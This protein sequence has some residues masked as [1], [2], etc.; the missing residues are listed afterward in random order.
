MRKLTTVW[1][2]AL[3]LVALAFIG[4][5]NA[6][7]NTEPPGVARLSFVRGGVSMQRGDSGD[8]SAADLNTPLV[9]G[10]KIFTGSGSRAEIQL[11]WADML[12][13]D[14]N[15]EAHIATLDNNNI[16]VQLAQG[17]AYFSILKGSQAS[18]EIDTPNVAINPRREG[19]FRI[20][21]TP[22]GE[23]LITARDGDAD[24]STPEGSTP[25]K[26]G[27][28][29]TV[30]GSGND[31][32]FQIAQAPGNDE[33]DRWNSDRD[34]I[35]A[36][37][38]SYRHTNPYYTGAADLDAYGSW[39]NVPDYGWVWVPRVAL[40]WAPYRHGRWVWEPYWGWTWSAY[41]P[42]GWAPYHYGRWFVYR[43]AW[44]WWPGPVTPFYR[45]VYAPA[46]VSFFGFGNGFSV[47]V[48]FGFGSIGWLPVGPC[49]YVHPWWGPHRSRFNVVSVTNI[50][51]VHNVSVI[52]PLRRGNRESNLHNML[53]NNQVRE[54]ISTVSAQTFGRGRGNFRTVS[55][56]E[57]RQGRFMTGNVPVV[58]SRESLRTSDRAFVAPART[59]RQERFFSRRVP[60]T[61]H[62]SF[63]AESARVRQGIDRSGF[64]AAS[65]EAGNRT[66]ANRS[67]GAAELNSRRQAP[68]ASPETRAPAARTGGETRGGWQRF[69]G[70]QGATTNSPSGRQAPVMRAP[71][72]R[73]SVPESSASRPAQNQ[74]RTTE[75][76]PGFQRFSSQRLQ[77]Q[78]AERSPAQSNGT[79]Q[80]PR[81]QAQQNS[82]SQRQS[83]WERFTGGPRRSTVNPRASSPQTDNRPTLDLNRPILRLRNAPERG[84]ATAPRSREYA[85]SNRERYVSPST[86]SSAPSSPGFSSRRAAPSGSS[87]GSRSA[88]RSSG[89]GARSAGGSHRGR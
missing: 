7:V 1:T 21:V 27:Q 64:G 75:A 60:S 59:Q 11:D 15:A 40:G 25:L 55:A 34:R 52:A 45:P 26:E 35:V 85:P 81:G 87:E 54:G 33:F 78:G 28:L 66:P 53:I 79:N 9:A 43:S 22:S 17:L 10:D 74:S 30:R 37:T 49:D 2:M 71:R 36:N 38:E 63:S 24:I 44:V 67:S 41:E 16:Q 68:Q 57:L 77:V 82:S 86:R 6:Q 47:G 48:S 19:R 76:Q 73:P 42:W 72:Q 58:P 70:N 32:Q 13:L 50:Y 61:Q 80:Q 8:I 12:R 39:D 46:Y 20:E 14:Q 69:G 3:A 88:P 5:A 84:Y 18:V 4:T 83:G 56:A 65:R 31:V 51:N 29:I 89:S 62:E 23:T